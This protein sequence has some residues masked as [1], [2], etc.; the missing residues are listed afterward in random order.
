MEKTEYYNK[1]TGEVTCRICGFKENVGL[2]LL[3]AT[4]KNFDYLCRRC[5]PKVYPEFRHCS[6]CHDLHSVSALE[7]LAD[8][9]EICTMCKGLYCLRCKMCGVLITE[10]QEAWESDEIGTWACSACAFGENADYTDIE[11]RGK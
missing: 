3:D 4:E 2:T 7:K 10:D 6:Y 8:G 5:A 11:R 1:D 9:R